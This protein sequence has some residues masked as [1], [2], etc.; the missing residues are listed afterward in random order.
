MRRPPVSKSV[1]L[2][3]KNLRT[4]CCVIALSAPQNV[5]FLNFRA[6]TLIF[7]LTRG[8]YLYYNDSCAIAHV[9]VFAPI[10]LQLR[11]E[12]CPRKGTKPAC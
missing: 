3:L 4:F 11:P 2:G 5:V 9:G 12:P 1:N 10:R 8:G 7:S 6:K